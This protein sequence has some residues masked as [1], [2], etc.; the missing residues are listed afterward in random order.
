MKNMKS[1]NTKPINHTNVMWSANV[2]GWTK[3]RSNTPPLSIASIETKAT[4]NGIKPVTIN[5]ADTFK[6]CNI[7]TK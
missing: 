5:N 7:L 3:T 4:N 2:T 1:P 6:A